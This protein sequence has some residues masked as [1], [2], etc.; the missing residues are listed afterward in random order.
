MD[1]SAA[2][3]QMCGVARQSQLTMDLELRLVE[4]HQPPTVLEDPPPTHS[5]LQKSTGTL[6]DPVYGLVEEH[7][8]QGRYSNQPDPDLGLV[9]EQQPVNTTT[10]PELRM[11][12]SPMLFEDLS[13]YSTTLLMSASMAVDRRPCE[14]GRGEPTPGWVCEPTSPCVRIG[15]GAPTCG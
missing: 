3:D 15:R 9:V 10:D 5:S 12:R 2:T 14:A 1:S 8:P 6:R 13:P 11:V 7:W 4:D